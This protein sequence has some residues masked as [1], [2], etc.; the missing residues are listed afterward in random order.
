MNT[1]FHLAQANVATL[2][3]PLESPQLAEFVGALEPINALADTSPGFVWR[4]QTGEGDATSIRVFADDRILLNM[5][6]WESIDALD[7]FVYRSAHTTVMRRR[8]EWFERAVEPYL[9][10]W[11]IP[12]GELPAAADAEPRLAALR[13]RGPTPFAFT[14]RRRF[15]APG[16]RLS[17]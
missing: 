2:L 17:R 11:W 12:E 6:V 15:P 4:L 8:A 3:A 9:V 1:A 10:L 7:D 16:G 5:S 13:E 14:L